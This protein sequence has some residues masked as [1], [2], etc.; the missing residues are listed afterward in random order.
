M[1][2]CERY[3]GCASTLPSVVM[4][5]CSPKVE[6]FTFAGRENRLVDVLPAARRVVL[7]RHDVDAVGGYHGVTVSSTALLVATPDVSDT[8]TANMA[9][10]S[11][12]TTAGMSVGSGCGAV[13][14]GAV[15]GP[16]VGECRTVA[17]D[18]ER[19]RASRHHRLRYGRDADDG[20]RCWRSWS[21]RGS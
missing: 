18:F 12:E 19:G 20:W 6:A 4:K 17:D 2:S 5:C 3:S 1:L 7:V 11:P 16:L 21:W 10:S 9:P 15:A 8:V 14:R 13:N